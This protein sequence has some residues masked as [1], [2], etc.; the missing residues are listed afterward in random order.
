MRQGLALI[1]AAAAAAAMPAVAAPRAE[2]VGRYDWAEDL[3]GFGGVSGIDLAPDGLSFRIITDTGMTLDG[4]FARNAA[5]AV[6]GTVPGRWVLLQ[7]EDPYPLADMVRDAEAISVLDD[8]SFF[9]AF[10]QNPRVEWY[11]SPDTVAKLRSD[12]L[13]LSNQPHNRSFEALAQGPDGAVYVLPEVPPAW[14]GPYPV[15]VLRDG[16]WTMPL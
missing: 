14:G 5:G 13:D 1:L 3:D 4:T 8:G 7:G 16:R 9:V 2:V 10:E 11:E 12:G 6:T 15:Q